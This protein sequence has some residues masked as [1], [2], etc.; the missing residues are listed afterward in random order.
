MATTTTGIVNWDDVPAYAAEFAHLGAT[1]RDLGRAAG[2]RTVGAR[3]IEI[4]ADR[5]STPVHVHADEE[6][7][8]H[9][10]G[11][12][13]LLWQG[14]ATYEIAA[15]DTIVHVAGGEPH[16]LRGGPDGLDLLVFGQRSAAALGHLPRA[17]VAWA[18]PGWV[19]VGVGKSPWEREADAGAPNCPPPSTPRPAN[20]VALDDVAG[21]FDGRAKMLGR[22]AGA[23]ATAF[24]LGTLPPG[25]SGAPA[26]CHSL[27][28]EIFVV[29]DGSGT[30]R[31]YEQGPGE[32]TE[33]PLRAGD[34][35]SRHAGTGIAHEIEPGD[36]GI[37]YLAFSAREPN[38]MCFYP[39]LGTVALRG[40]GVSFSPPG[41]Q[42]R[43]RPG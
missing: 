28:E 12:S 17:G 40:L 8:F 4:A 13:G 41:L 10:L 32:P 20:V 21:V 1:W 23:L 6:E 33:H 15:G 30:M 29:L 5:F 24:N 2:T 34:T 39:Q 27:E 7:V 36:E 37:S 31:L 14:G 22:A 26:H 43:P 38:D 25:G 11:G 9:V 42:W 19:E 35:I 16:T 3:R 18:I